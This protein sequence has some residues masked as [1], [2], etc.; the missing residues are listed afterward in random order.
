MFGRGRLLVDGW[1]RLAGRPRNYAC[2]L[3]SVR[4]I[5]DRKR[6]FLDGFLNS[7]ADLGKVSDASFHHSASFNVTIAARRVANRN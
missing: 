1:S 5:V 4:V 3:C 7:V 2:G 6:W